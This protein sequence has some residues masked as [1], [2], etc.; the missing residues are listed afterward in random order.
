MFVSSSNTA[1]ASA[2][3]ETKTMVVSRTIPT[4]SVFSASGTQEQTWIVTLTRRD[5]FETSLSYT[6]SRSFEPFTHTWTKSARAVLTA[7]LETQDGAVESI[8]DAEIRDATLLPRVYLRLTCVGDHFDIPKVT[9]NLAFWFVY[10]K[11][12][13]FKDTLET[14][15]SVFP[16][17]RMEF[18]VSFPKNVITHTLRVPIGTID[19]FHVSEETV[20]RIVPPVDVLASKELFITP[21]PLYVT[22]APLP[23][24]GYDGA[25]QPILLLSSIAAWTS[26]TVLS[27][28]PESLML[29]QTTVLLGSYGCAELSQRNMAIY[30]EWVLSPFLLAFRTRIRLSLASMLNF[31]IFAIF[32]GCHVALLYTLQYRRHWIPV[33][34]LC[35]LQI[36]VTARTNEIHRKLRFPNLSIA[37]GLLLT[38]GTL[39]LSFHSFFALEDSPGLV[40]ISAIVFI[41]TVVLWS[42][43]LRFFFNRKVLRHRV[44]YHR[45]PFLTTRQF[46]AEAVFFRG[47]WRPEGT[48][49]R[50]G[51]LYAS[52]RST[53][54]YFLCP[55]LLFVTVIGL[56]SSYPTKSVA[57]CERQMLIGVVIQAIYFMYF[58]MKRPLRSKL[59]N[60][61][62]SF[63][64]ISQ[65]ASV[66][67]TAARAKSAVTHLTLLQVLLTFFYILFA[68]ALSLYEHFV[69]RH[70]VERSFVV[71]DSNNVVD[72]SG[73][74]KNNISSDQNGYDHFDDDDDLWG[75]MTDRD[76]ELLGDL[77]RQ[78][79]VDDGNEND[80][81]KNDSNDNNNTNKT[82]DATTDGNVN[83]SIDFLD[84]I[85]KNDA[86]QIRRRSSVGFSFEIDGE[87]KND[88]VD[89]EDDPY[90]K[91]DVDDL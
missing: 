28:S 24:S 47:A 27:A 62:M 67:S 23:H 34:I 57:A 13:K 77:S 33:S 53:A 83:N 21:K 29:V 64:L 86:S 91:V 60:M 69:Q 81:N 58:V 32:A 40:F 38:P 78:F 39:A 42:L 46:L 79:I 52:F 17:D 37:V 12:E 50:Y 8:S 20:H 3:A 26:S 45:Y 15:R 84:G 9:H 36:P 68:I 16:S 10:V 61:L 89:D 63:V 56:L 44:R 7:S 87:H 54:M 35:W 19:G 1:E 55:T 71:R 43:M 76:V 65:A 75:D 51:V 4:R 66:M 48:V 90:K 18:D 85:L 11:G 5:T 72:F 25:T 14:F 6:R 30:N 22:I 59:L 80:E 2:S 41:A 49:T 31:I 73:G 74:A 88:L 82:V 70:H